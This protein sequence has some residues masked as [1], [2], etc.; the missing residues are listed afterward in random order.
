MSDLVVNPRH[1]FSDLYSTLQHDFGHTTVW[2]WE[3]QGFERQVTVLDLYTFKAW[4]NFEEGEV[5]CRSVSCNLCSTLQ[6]DPGHTTVW[7]WEG[8]DS[9]RQVTILDLET[10][11]PR[12]NMVLEGGEVTCMAR[13]GTDV[14]VGSE[15]CIK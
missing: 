6:H 8:E 15:V 11:K 4:Q 13:V 12:Q 10:S 2:L 14:W 3:S 9:E 5:T 1:I 7:L